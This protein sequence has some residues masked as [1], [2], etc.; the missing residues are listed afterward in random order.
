MNPFERFY[1][2]RQELSTF[3][4]AI[5][6][7]ADRPGLFADRTR[8]TETLRCLLRKYPFLDLYYALDGEDRRSTTMRCT[9]A[10]ESALPLPAPTAATRPI[11][12]RRSTAGPS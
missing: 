4:G 8:L 6:E 2:A 3:L 5:L 12:G 10:T 7:V 1:E 9:P 11:T